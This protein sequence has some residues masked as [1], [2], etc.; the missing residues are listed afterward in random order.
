MMLGIRST[1]VRGRRNRAPV[2]RLTPKLRTPD[3]VYKILGPKSLN[4][5]SRNVRPRTEAPGV[6][7]VSTS[8]GI[9]DV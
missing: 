4:C 8:A 6:L 2:P 3:R 5:R 1:G 7:I 9:S